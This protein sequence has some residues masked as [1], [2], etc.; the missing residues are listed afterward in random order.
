MFVRRHTSL[1]SSYNTAVKSLLVL[2]QMSPRFNLS[3]LGFEVLGQVLSMQPHCLTTGNFFFA[4]SSVRSGKEKKLS[5]YSLWPNPSMSLVRL[6]TVV[7]ITVRCAAL[8][9]YWGKLSCHVYPVELHSLNIL[10]LKHLCFFGMYCLKTTPPLK[11]HSDFI[12][13]QMFERVVKFWKVRP[14]SFK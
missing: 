1:L 4:K 10:I 2:T 5:M 3:V 6:V 8:C 14:Y 13:C 9:L 11:F 12:Y 7:W